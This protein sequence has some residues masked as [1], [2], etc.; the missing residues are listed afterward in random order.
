[1]EYLVKYS[2]IRVAQVQPLTNI[3]TDEDTN[4]IDIDYI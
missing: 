4:N 1:M 2:H 3:K